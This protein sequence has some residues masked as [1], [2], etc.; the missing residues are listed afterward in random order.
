MVI[1]MKIKRKRIPYQIIALSYLSVIL[2]GTILL[3]LPWSI[4]SG[5]HL[6][7]ADAFFMATSSVCVTG[8]SVVPNVGSSFT[9]FGKIVMAVLIEIGGLSFITFA[10]FF[11]IITGS[12]IGIANRFLIKEALNQNSV[13]GIVKLIKVIIKIAFLIQIMGS[14]I[15]FFAFIPF[16]SFWQTIGISIFHS[17]SSFNNAGFDIFGFDSSMIPYASNI[18]L[19]VNT[20]FLIILGGIGFLVID[21]VMRRKHWRKFSLNTK[22]VLQTTFF[23]IIFG[24]LSLKLAMNSSF[25][26][27]Q[28]LFLSVS[29]RTAGFASTDISK[30]NN[31][32]YLT[33]IFLMFIGASPTST[34]GG[35]KTTT[36]FVLIITIISY[37]R[38]RQTNAYYRKIHEHSIFKAFSLVALA[39][40]FV[41]FIILLISFFEPALGIK[42]IAF[43]VISAFGTV[44]LSMGITSYLSIISKLL[45]CLTMFFGRLGP[46]TMISIWNSRW[47]SEANVNI[48]Y[49]EEKI[50]IG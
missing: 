2:F 20:M 25:T 10:V 35:L 27:L 1:K 13:T 28:A 50:I 21:E 31:P 23:L 18:L 38:G 8:L 24:T 12:K 6:N 49:V 22:I 4:K 42:E 32:A 45:L 44:G 17:I 5:E 7:L 15:N 3:W 11:F 19:N 14:V 16:Y 43:E 39:L 33:L 9:I 34:G 46:L 26:W 40:M 29:S 47:L 41:S 48:Q 36:L 30:I 37:A